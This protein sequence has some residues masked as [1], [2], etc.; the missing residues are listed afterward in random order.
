MSQP[1]RPP[2]AS[3]LCS[4]QDRG[5]ARWK[6]ATVCS[7]AGERLWFCFACVASST[8][9]KA[10]GED[11]SRGLGSAGFRF[12][13]SPQPERAKPPCSGTRPGC[14]P[15]RRCIE[16]CSQSPTVQPQL[17]PQL[18]TELRFWKS[19]AGNHLLSPAKLVPTGSAAALGSCSQGRLSRW[20]RAQPEVLLELCPRAQVPRND[21][22]R[23]AGCTPRCPH[24]PGR[25]PSYQVASQA[26]MSRRGQDPLHCPIRPPA[27]LAASICTE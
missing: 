15:S 11:F 4:R 14:S 5:H 16:F 23:K 10:S 18:L 26:P 20:H 25:N 2:P 12:P 7:G 17:C 6:A 9:G 21:G 13:S 3:Q 1:P 19:T 22:L 24:S 8:A 27:F